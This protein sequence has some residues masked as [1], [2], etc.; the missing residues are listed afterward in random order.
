[1]CLHFYIS[2][3]FYA[4]PYFVF[5]KLRQVGQVKSNSVML[6]STDTDD[7]CRL[8]TPTTAF[9]NESLKIEL[10]RLKTPLDGTRFEGRNESTENVKNE[11]AENL[12]WLFLT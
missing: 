12:K 10:F 8:E 1:M 5:V 2:R 7:G 9:Y 11:F 4:Y 6:F 3:Y